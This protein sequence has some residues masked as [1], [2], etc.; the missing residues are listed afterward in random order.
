MAIKASI[1]IRQRIAIGLGAIVLVMILLAVVTWSKLNGIERAVGVADNRMQMALAAEEL[2]QSLRNSVAQTTQYA[3]NETNFDQENAKKALDDLINKANAFSANNAAVGD[4]ALSIIAA[5]LDDYAKAVKML[6]EAIDARHTGSDAFNRAAVMLQ[7]TTAAIPNTMLNENRIATVA[8]SIKL[9][10]NAQAATASVSRYL[11]TRDPAQAAAAKQSVIDLNNAIAV[12]RNDAADSARIQKIVRVLD[13]QLTSFA[14]SLD[15][16]ITA[17]D[18]AAKAHQARQQA[19]DTL[20]NRID[21]VRQDSINDQTSAMKDVS[22]S[23]AIARVVI[24]ASS[25]TGLFIA[26]IAW[27]LL[28]VNIVFALRRLKAA[29]HRLAQG[30]LSI[31]I[32]DQHRADEIGNMARAVGVFKDN[33]CA[34]ERMRTEQAEYEQHLATSKQQA[35]LDMATDF[36]NHVNAMVNRVATASKEMN[37]ASQSMATVAEQ[38]SQQA[39]RAVEAMTHASGNVRMVADATERLTGSIAEISRHVSHAT[40]ISHTAVDRARQTGTVIR[41]LS[42]AVSQIGEVVK[43][44]DAIAAQTNLLA[45]NATIEAARAGEAGK[46]FAVVA[47]EVKHLAGQTAKATHEIGQ[48]I[49]AIQQTTAEAVRAINDIQL[50]ITDISQATTAIASA[51]SEQQTVTHEIVL[52]VEQATAGTAQVAENITIVTAAAGETGRTADHV[53]QEA[54]ELLKTSEGLHQQVDSFLLRIKA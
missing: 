38:T 32:S 17:T 43:L 11:A 24:V 5:S 47:G 7:T 13:P 40:D 28:T 20:I 18:K 21:G 46:G 45:L 9:E 31:E 51:V 10:E 48:Q 25:I 39:G 16:L 35:V 26:L 2:T 19:A 52:N 8:A 53:L 30:D 22:A 49:N 4:K 50:T 3:L 41:C 34:M 33:A 6:F 23:V 1:N 44:I 12:I 42:D 29:M 15:T 36:E 14:Q 54:H 37:S 27:R